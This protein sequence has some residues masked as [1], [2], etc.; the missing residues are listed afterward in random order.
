M[1]RDLDR[2]GPKPRTT[3]P[4]RFTAGTGAFGSRGA[5]VADASEAVGPRSRSMAA[6]DTPDG[7]GPRG[8]S[9]LPLPPR[10]P[11]MPVARRK[12]AVSDD[13][14][15]DALNNRELSRVRAM[16]GTA[17]TGYKRGGMVKKPAAA[18]TKPR[19]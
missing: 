16:N 9:D 5:K 8:G 19:R 15:A 1:A 11:P 12:P 3:T 2:V 10:K 6:M 4:T 7:T 18:K 14:A 17:D 13:G